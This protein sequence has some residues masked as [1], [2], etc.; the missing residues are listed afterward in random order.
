LLESVEPTVSPDSASARAQT[1]S[2]LGICCLRCCFTID[3][4]LSS[5]VGLKEGG[6]AINRAGDATLERNKCR[7]HDGSDHC[8]NDAVLS[9]RLTFLDG[10][11]GAEV[12][13][14][15]RER[16]D[17]SPPFRISGARCAHERFRAS[18]SGKSTRVPTKLRCTPETSFLFSARRFA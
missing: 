6:N 14:Q 2:S 16:H 5:A 18:W 8:Q 9:H 4:L 13:N 3:L 10:K 11:P 1:T 7:N 15:I 12:R 17:D